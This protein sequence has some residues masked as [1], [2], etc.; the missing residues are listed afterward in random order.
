MLDSPEM[1]MQSHLVHGERLL[2]SGNPRRGITLQKTDFVGFGFA[3]FGVVLMGLYAVQAIG[4]SNYIFL[5]FLIPFAIIW[6]SVAAGQPIWRARQ[7]RNAVYGLT[8]RRALIMQS[9]TSGLQS[10][11]LASESTVT[12]Q[13]HRDGTGTIWFGDQ[14]AIRRQQEPGP[15]FRS[16]D[17]ANAVYQRI[18]GIQTRPSAE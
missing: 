1:L 5:V 18:Q 8:D 4:D 9:K 11:S 15:A 3:L 7:L 6:I 14:P 17:D 12:L 10:V 16:I 2:W 13:T